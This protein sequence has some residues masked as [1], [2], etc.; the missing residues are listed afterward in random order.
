MA[1]RDQ[2]Q[3]F[4][5]IG[6][7]LNKPSQPKLPP[8]N[9]IRIVL[10]TFLYAMLPTILGADPFLP[11]SIR[12]GEY[13]ITTQRLSDEPIIDYDSSPTLG[14]KING[15]SVIRVPSWISNPLGK[16]YLYFAHHDG[17]FIRLAYADRIAGPWTV[18]EP[19]TLSLDES[20]AFI[21]HIASPD[22]H[23]D[24][25][26]QS[27]RMYYH[28]SR[29][30]TNQRT[31]T[32][33]SKDGVRFDA[34]NEVIGSSY[35][36]V[37]QWKDAYYA[38]DAHG[39]LNRSDEW[40]SG[41]E[42]APHA[43]VPPI[44]IDDEFGY[45]EDLRIRHS[46]VLVKNDTLFLFYTRKS[47]APERILVSQIDLAT[48]WTQW[49]ASEPIELLRPE[50]NY[51]GIQYAIAPSK[52]GGGKEVQQLRDPYVFEDTDGQ[53]YLFYSTAGEMGLAVARLE[54]DLNR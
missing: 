30:T 20:P 11:K 3:R 14:F 48:D 40:D 10:I 15:P 25:A 17:K 34:S 52:K 18:Y 24:H 16:Y 1:F 44:A 23:V 47:D 35:F 12:S 21:G 45:R 5:S 33:T 38:I 9:A 49:T 7:R 13:R 6:A 51:E 31:A 41:W 53:L 43:L 26:N 36:R 8:V 32:A 42:I 27:I 28:G 4:Q 39:F 37:F 2:A 22:V 54:I 50:T 19:G 29:E 46:A